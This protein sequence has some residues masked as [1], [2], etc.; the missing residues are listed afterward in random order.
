M[1]ALF[2]AFISATQLTSAATGALTHPLAGQLVAIAARLDSLE[3][4]LREDIAFL[5]TRCEPSPNQVEKEAL[6]NHH[7]DE[8]ERFKLDTEEVSG[9]IPNDDDQ[10][11]FLESS[12]NVGIDVGAKPET[13]NRLIGPAD[14][15]KKQRLKVVLK[16]HGILD[17]LEPG[18]GMAVDA[19]KNDMA[20][21]LLYQAIRRTSSTG[22]S[23]S[24]A[25]QIWEALKV[26]FVGVDRV[27]EARLQTLQS[28]LESMKMSDSEGID[29]F[30]S[31]LSHLVSKA[32]SLGSTIDDRNLV[33]KLLGSVPERF[34]AIVASIEQFADLNVMSFQEAIG[35]LK[36]FEE[37]TRMKEK[38]P[39]SKPEQL[40]LSY[41]EWQAKRRPEPSQGAA[42]GARRQG[43][44]GRGRGPP[45]RGKTQDQPST[46]YQPRKT[47][48]REKIKCFRCDSMGHY[49]SECPTRPK[50]ETNLT[51][52]REDGPALM[53]ALVVFLNEE[54][55]LPKRNVPGKVRFGDGSCVN[56]EGKGNIVLECKTRDQR[57][58]S[59]VYYIPTMKSNISL[60]QL[61]Q[62]GY[63]VWMKDEHLWVFEA[64]GTLLM[65]VPRSLNRLYKTIL[66]VA[67]PVC[68]LASVGVNS[69]WLWHARLSHLNFDAIQKQ[70][71]NGPRSAQ[72]HS[73]IPGCVSTTALNKITVLD[74]YPIP[75]IDELL[76]ELHGAT[77][78]SKLD[79]RSGYYQVRNSFFAK[80]TKCCFGQSQVMFLGHLVSYQ[81]VQ[82]DQEKISAIQNW[83]IPTN[84]KEVRGFL[85]LTGYYRRFIR[86][87]G[88][89]ARPLTMLTK[90][91][92]FTWSSSALSAFNTLKDA[93]MSAPILRLPDFSKPFTIE[94]LNKITIADKYPI[95]NID[96]LLDEL[97]GATIFSKLDLRSGYY[98]I[99]VTETDVP[100]TAFRTHSGHYEF[101]VMPFGLTNAPSTF[102]AIMNDLFRPFLR[103]FVLVF[104]DDILIY[105]RD[106]DQHVYHLDT[107]LQLLQSHS[108]FVKLSKCCFGQS[109]VN[110]LGHII[111]SEG[112]KVEEEKIAAVKS[113]PIPQNVTQVRGFL[114]LTGYYRRFVRNYG[115]IARP[116]TALTKK[117]GFHWNDDA[118]S[119]FNALK[120]ALTTAPVLHLPDFDKEFVVECDA[121]SDGVGAIL[122]QAEHPIAYFS[123]G[124]TP[125]TRFKSA[126]DREL[127]ALVLA[128]QKWNHYL[129]GRH[130]LIRTDHYTLKFL[131][132][133]RVTTTE[134]Q[135]LLLKLM[136]YDFSILHRAGKENRG[137]DA[138]SRRPMCATLLTLTVP[139][140]VDVG[141]I[142]E[143]LQTDPFTLDLLNKL[144]NSSTTLPDFSLADGFLFYR[145][146]L[147]IP[148]VPGLRMKLLQE[149]HDTPIG[150]H[151]G[152]L[153]TLK[154]LSSQYF[155]PQMN[156]DI[157][158]HVQNCITC[159]QQ[160]YQTT[161]PAGLLQPLPIPNQIWED[162]SM[163]FIVG[164]PP[165]NRFD[166]ILVVIDRLSKYAHFLSLAHPFTAK[167]VANLFCKEIVRLHG[168][169]RSI[170]SD[171]DVVFLSHFWQELFRLSHTKLNLSSSYHPQTD[172]QSEV[173]NR[174][175]ESY[176]RCFAQEQPRKWNSFLPW[177]EYSYNTGFHSATG[178]TPF[179]AVYGRPPPALL[180]YVVGE[181][182]NAELEKQLLDRD[183]ML[184]L[185]RDNLMKAQDRMRNQANT[186]RRDVSFDVGDYV[187]LRLQPYRQRSLSKRRFE[188][189]SPRFFGPYQ[190]KRKVGPVAYELDLPSTASIHPVFHVSLLKPARGVL[191]SNPPAP[192]PI[193]KDYELELTPFE[194]LQ[195]R[196]VMEA[197]RPVLELLVS[198]CNRPVEEATWESY[199]LFST[200]FPSFRLED[201]S[202][203]QGGSN[204]T[205]D[206]F[207]VYK[208]RN[209]RVANATSEV[210]LDYLLADKMDPLGQHSM[211]IVGN[212]GSFTRSAGAYDLQPHFVVSHR[213]VTDSGVRVLELLI[214]WKNR[215]LEEATWESYD[216]L[217][218]QFPFFVLEDKFVFEEGCIDTSTPIHVYTR[219]NKNKQ[220]QSAVTMEQ[221]ES[222][223]LRGENNED[224]EDEFV[225]SSPKS[226]VKGRGPIL[227][228]Q[229]DDTNGMHD[230]TKAPDERYDHTPLRGSEDIEVIYEKTKD[231][232]LLLLEGEPT[233]YNY[234]Q[235]IREWEEAMA[236]EA[237]SIE[238]NKTWE[239]TE[240]PAGVV[241]IGLKWVFKIKR[242]VS[243]HKARLVAK[244]YVQQHG[245]D[246]E[247]VF[248][249]V[250]RIE[251]VRLILAV[252]A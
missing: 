232:Q 252:A 241:P 141:D 147:V 25:K 132:E 7:R 26:R 50:E 144:Q 136:P 148:D 51:E 155:W 216:L 2:A 110:F 53:M 41:D 137:A 208:R 243:K 73:P 214:S 43:P 220:K 106:M 149:A 206:Q 250:A 128:V 18:I 194:V 5:K 178:I 66:K 102:Q 158:L 134:Q 165:S 65:K 235:G 151:G 129:F 72:D 179:Y 105:S 115:I 79:L 130:F 125:T 49:A 111:T 8:E 233:S 89:I 69:A 238:K 196:W 170:V 181:T 162:V 153:K 27:R 193:T 34:L 117:N 80:L 6:N 237:R 163:D 87:Y 23:M 185:L 131:L 188:K 32:N 83:P 40:L 24:N 204:V 30:A 218:A 171:R 248:A 100:K 249:P 229:H 93:L 114:G 78:F 95:P 108:F 143:G 81:G 240:R 35:R 190:I 33:R 15:I 54:R 191:P 182:N 28:K 121:S 186:K 31:R 22:V 195:H 103:K 96:E 120:T 101:K 176:L 21:A 118:W 84:V 112:V 107:T 174:C 187:F 199:D 10:F 203:Y 251:T 91:D 124:F 19:K 4:H 76:D 225:W 184:K 169:P 38:Q 13:I 222:V 197:N 133:Q 46:S 189:L 29:E 183:D 55:V 59:E 88:I 58:L 247:E 42:R 11:Q 47:K 36:A 92:G 127:L 20:V 1:P 173:L 231:S 210:E 160:K 37:R 116:L 82:V 64:N 56:I 104:F 202:F 157:R 98:Q 139:F 75:T 140:C 245:V 167:T 213:W 12:S 166:T 212:M 97:Y 198:W 215:P 57:I 86:D 150:G 177:A 211:G 244:G 68:L 145:K 52:A 217:A 135:R 119:A 77:V 9:D 138:L 109:H 74:K 44:R 146:R 60:G 172:G 236:A 168:F 61:T 126:Y 180:P 45:C 207:K 3:S 113:W 164:L 90:K 63:E 242:E 230:P 70:F 209:K 219:R 227:S 221:L 239:I 14:W 228:R 39:C 122:S 71:I 99:R 17:A 200:Q 48:D 123:K 226:T 16:V 154:R 156:K 152:F 201:K 85:G 224:S 62:I 159:Q 161:S 142:R 205:T 246:F 94:A 234:A 192:L 67:S 223:N 175:L